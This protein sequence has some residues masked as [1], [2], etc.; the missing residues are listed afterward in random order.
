MC[1][2]GMRSCSHRENEEVDRAIHHLLLNLPV[3]SGSFGSTD[4]RANVRALVLAG[5]QNQACLAAADAGLW[6]EA[7]ILSSPGASDELHRTVVSRFTEHALAADDPL[8]TLL[9]VFAGLP[10]SFANVSSRTTSSGLYDPRN[11]I[12]G[13]WRDTLVMVLRN[14]PSQAGFV[15]AHTGEA[16]LQEGKLCAAHLWYTQTLSGHPHTT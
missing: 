7:M 12:S 6:T 9:N 8:R 4:P 16:L 5:E 1:K 10:P 13:V 15:L 14:C 2:I 11:D 3:S